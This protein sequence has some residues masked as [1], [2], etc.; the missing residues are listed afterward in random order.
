[1]D[2]Y[3]QYLFLHGRERRH[4]QCEEWSLETY[5]TGFFHRAGITRDLFKL[6]ILS[7]L[8]TTAPKMEHRRLGI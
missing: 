2:A 5:P 8:S 7:P 4:R 3:L 1:M 6:G